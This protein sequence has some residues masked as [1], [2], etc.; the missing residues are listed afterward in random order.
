MHTL[1]SMQNLSSE[2]QQ[3]LVTI[4]QLTEQV[5]ALTSLKRSSSTSDQQPSDQES[6]TASQATDVDMDSFPGLENKDK[7]GV[8]TGDSIAA[9]GKAGGNRTGFSIHAG[10]FSDEV[11]IFISVHSTPY[12]LGCG[13]RCEF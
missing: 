7:G 12:T 1:S 2:V 10:D 6:V 8:S 9:V 3:H 11:S 13:A 4:Q 5:Q